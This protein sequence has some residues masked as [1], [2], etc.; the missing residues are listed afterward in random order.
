MKFKHLLYAGAALLALSACSKEDAGTQNG[1]NESGEG[2]Y[3]SLS[4][5]TGTRSVNTGGTTTDPGTD[6]EQKVNSLMVLVYNAA[7]DSFDAIGTYEADDLTPSGP[8]TPPIADNT[9][10]YTTKEPLKVQSAGAKKVVVIVNPI[11][12]WFSENTLLSYMHTAKVI[13]AG[14]MDDSQGSI[15]TFVMTN[16]NTALS[17]NQDKSAVTAATPN[18]E[19][20]YPDGSFAVEVQG[21]KTNPTPVTIPVER[22]VAKIVDKTEN[23]T[24]DVTETEGDQVT[25]TKV[26]LING[27]KHFF[28]VKKLRASSVDTNDYVVDPNFE[29]QTPESASSNFMNPSAEYFFDDTKGGLNAR[30]LTDGTPVHF[31]ALENTMIANEQKNVYTTGLYYQAVYKVSGGT[32]NENVYKYLGKV[33]NFEGLKSAATSLS[34]NL[35]GLNNDSEASAFA[36]VGVTKYTDGVCY[37]PYWIRHVSDDDNT[38]LGVMEFAVVRNNRYEMTIKSVKGIGTPDPVDPDETPDESADVYL[39]VA[40]KVLPWTVRSNEIEF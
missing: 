37:Y 31:Y 13:A 12:G 17:E 16:A 33:Y 32:E 2:A 23:Y 26:A 40:V 35:N 15:K 9:T 10:V 30:N 11:D 19:G 25:F 18:Q 39:Q 34:L 8:N 38:K 6:A 21:T 27:N 3:L 14:E 22:I 20:F 4:I 7:D 29:G 28:P 24:K 5:S 36:A 1:G